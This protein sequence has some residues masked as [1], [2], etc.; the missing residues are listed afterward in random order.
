MSI[1]GSLYT[2]V[3]GLS[4]QSN[5]IGMISNNIANVSTVGYKRIDASFSSLVTSDTNTGTYSPGSVLA[6]QTPTINQQGILQQSSSPTDIAISGNGF[7]MVKSSTTDPLAA[8]YYTRA[9]SFSTDANGNLVNTGGFY[10]YGWPLDQNGNI[11]AN[12]SNI[13]SLVPVNTAFLGGLTQPTSS[14]AIDMNLN[15]AATSAT[16]PISSST[17][18]S[19]S[20]AV[21]VYDSLGTGH[22]LTLNFT[23]TTTP[24]ASVTGTVDISK[25]TG[26]MAGQVP[27]M[28]STDSFTIST[29]G[30]AVT[31]TTINSGGTV[32]DM[33]AQINA[34]KDPTT[35]QPLLYAQLDP[36]TGAL[37]IASR[38]IGDT[39]SVANVNGTPLTALGLNTQLQSQAVGNIDTT[40]YSQTSLATTPGIPPGSGFTL[41]NS[42]T[43]VTTPI[44][45]NAGMTDLLAQLNG[46]TGVAASVDSA[47]GFL[48]I[49][50][51]NNA[52]LTLTDGAGT[53]LATYFGIAAAPTTYNVTGLVPPPS[54]TP[55]LLTPLNAANNTSTDGWWNVS[56]TTPSG[57]VVSS[58]AINFTG[59]GLLNAIP[60]TNQQVLTSLNNIDWGN[61]SNP[62]T[63]NF[64]MAGF[65]QFAS[66]YDIVAS[67]QNGAALG[68]Q[69][70]VSID[71][72]GFVIAQFSNGQSQK[73]YQLPVTTFSNPNG[74][75][76]ES[77]NAFSQTDK[78]GTYNLRLSNTGGAGSISSG[79]LEASN[80]DLATEFSSMIVTQ[81]AYAA[82]S[83]VITTANQMTQAL[84]QIQP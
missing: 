41:K 3:S 50:S 54:K 45:I 38:N 40:T 42:V 1:F 28:T 76:S 59:A 48:D 72:N 58:G 33:L 17:P 5:A 11:P 80:V 20:T 55:N 47:T 32:S 27:G 43:G 19:Y 65:T 74:L 64:D 44:T 16:Y 83:K 21:E 81:E 79:T 8:P 39:F 82:N 10:L 15:S 2:A 56:F 69:T 4:A 12:A 61:G 67:H 37:N 6:S 71:K 13:S 25:V 57:A 26:N 78:S 9:G 53:P 30:T 84:L 66:G 60:D 7:F 51:T 70:G 75:N 14:A 22:N 18:S 63:I 49:R 31:A 73:I 68:L 52:A 62:Q 29:T 77:G 46:I 35:G 34:I 24:T 36:V 23:K